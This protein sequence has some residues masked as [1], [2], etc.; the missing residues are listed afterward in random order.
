MLFSK[1][2]NWGVKIRDVFKNLMK[3]LF[4]KVRVRMFE[5]INYLITGEG[6][7]VFIYR[8]MG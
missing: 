2:E 8:F 3:C 5:F 4:L 7:S 6:K 1:F